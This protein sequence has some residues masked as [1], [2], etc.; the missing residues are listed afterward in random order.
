MQNIIKNA[1]M[2][3]NFKRGEPGN[4]YHMM[5][6]VGGHRVTGT[7]LFSYTV[8]IIIFWDYATFTNSHCDVHSSL[9]CAKFH[10]CVI[11]GNPGNEARFC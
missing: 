7:A 6:D 8:H 4:Y 2:L 9:N 5:M 10:V 1:Y 11:E 3:R